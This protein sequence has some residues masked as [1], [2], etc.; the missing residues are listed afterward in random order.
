MKRNAI[1]L[2]SAII[3]SG[4]VCA[5]PQLK[6]GEY[7]NFSENSNIFSIKISAGGKAVLQEF[8]GTK[9]RNTVGSWTQEGG[10]LTMTFKKRVMTYE[11]HDRLRSPDTTDQKA[12]KCMPPNGLKPITI[13]GRSDGL[14]DYY[15][16]S[17][18]AIK[19]NGLPCA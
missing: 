15:L 8:D 13:E 2:A 5:G 4:V 17:A 19:K 6:I 1:I 18:Q 12:Q 16:W 10:N 14:M 9:N 3:G 7:T 11:I